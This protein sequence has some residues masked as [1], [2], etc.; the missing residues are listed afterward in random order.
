MAVSVP[1]PLLVSHNFWVAIGAELNQQC[2]VLRIAI[3]PILWRA[4]HQLGAA[5]SDDAT[6]SS[7]AYA[8]SSTSFWTCSTLKWKSNLLAISCTAPEGMVSGFS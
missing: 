4:F 2:C 3:F 5:V 1:N 8:P 7:T 6:I